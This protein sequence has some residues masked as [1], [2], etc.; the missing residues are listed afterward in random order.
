MRRTATTIVALAVLVAGATSAAAASAAAPRVLDHGP[1]RM[2]EDPGMSGSRYVNYYPGQA[3]DNK[4][5]IG[6]WN[7][8]NEIS[9][10]D[11]ATSYWVTLWDNDNY[12]GTRR[13]IAPHTS[14]DDLNLIGYDNRAESFQLT[15]NSLC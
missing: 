2:W 8:D 12:T 7:G 13:C 6:G 1:V 10:V 15:S 14:V 11:N 4:V 5:N 9:A 3:A